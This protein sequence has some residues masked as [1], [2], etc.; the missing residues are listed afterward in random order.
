[1]IILP[2]V[3]ASNADMCS[4]MVLTERDT[5]TGT[6]AP[7]QRTS[8]WTKKKNKKQESGCD[9]V[10]RGLSVTYNHGYTVTPQRQGLAR[11]GRRCVWWWGS[12][13]F[14]ATLV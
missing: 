4:V 14:G 10:R 3:G 8:N 2:A 13:R 11:D 5:A 6:R 1:M 7:V 12:K 9:T